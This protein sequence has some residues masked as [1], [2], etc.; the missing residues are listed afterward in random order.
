MFP[1]KSILAAVALG[2]STVAIAAPVATAQGTTVVVI[3]QAKIMRDSKA[4][5][6]IQTKLEAIEGAM[7]RELQPTAD[8]LN[9]EGQAIEAKTANMTPEAMRADAA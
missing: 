9:A 2:T 5:K 8:Q 3:D 7:E 4:G 1:I 6:D